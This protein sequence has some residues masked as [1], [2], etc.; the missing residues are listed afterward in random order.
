MTPERWERVKTLYDAARVRAVGQ[1]A[2]FLARECK[3]DTDLQ[4][5]VE[6]LLDQPF[7]TADFISFVGGPAP[8]L[9]GDAVHGRVGEILPGRTLDCLLGS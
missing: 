9:A 6:A 3:G 1:R 7:G 2:T 8:A 4:L 5:E